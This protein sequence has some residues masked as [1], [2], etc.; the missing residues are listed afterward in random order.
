MDWLW[1]CLYFVKKKFIDFFVFIILFLFHLISLASTIVL[2][3]LKLLLTAYW[4]LEWGEELEMA[5]LLDVFCFTSV[6]MAMKLWNG[7]WSMSVK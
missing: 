1:V 2:D 3:R 7:V 4:C 6:Q 5:S